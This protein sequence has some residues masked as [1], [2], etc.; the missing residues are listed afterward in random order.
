MLL[1]A[2]SAYAADEGDAQMAEQAAAEEAAQ[3]QMAEEET[4]TTER[5]RMLDTY[6]DELQREKAMAAGE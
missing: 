2:G 3:M 6:E 4:L 5:Q 1:F